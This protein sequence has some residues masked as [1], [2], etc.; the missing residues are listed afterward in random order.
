MGIAHVCCR[1]TCLCAVWLFLLSIRHGLFALS[2]L[3]V[4]H[5]AAMPKVTSP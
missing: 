3:Y 1:F 5:R 2:R 4:M